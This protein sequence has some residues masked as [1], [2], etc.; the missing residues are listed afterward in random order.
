MY[1]DTTHHTIYIHDVSKATAFMFSLEENS[2]FRNVV[3][4]FSVVCNVLRQRVLVPASDV[5]HS[6]GWSDKY[7]LLVRLLCRA[8]VIKFTPLRCSSYCVSSCGL[9]RVLSVNDGQ[10]VGCLSFSSFPFWPQ[11]LV[12]L[13]ITI[14]AR[15]CV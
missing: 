9:W 4:V 8:R 3:N 2:S 6:R 13:K 10:R 15:K 5:L 1:K 12:A 11:I 14:E 7:D